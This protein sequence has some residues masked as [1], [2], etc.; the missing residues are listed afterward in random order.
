MTMVAA[1][2][3]AARKTYGGG[4]T[5]IPGYLEQEVL[6]W[7]PEK[8][9]LKTYELFLLSAKKDDKRRMTK[10]LIELI[11]ALNYEHGGELAHRLHRLYEYCQRCVNLNKIDEAVAIISELRDSWEKTFNLSSM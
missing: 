3:I 9:T 6:L 5:K 11:S 1:Q 7:S 10:V 8:I 2:R 4:D